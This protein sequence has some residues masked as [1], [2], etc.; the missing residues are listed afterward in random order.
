ME[1]KNDVI[2]AVMKV[3]RAMHR[4]PPKGDGL[5]PAMGRTLD[6]LAAN[7]GATSRELAE[8]LDVR[9]SSLTEM[10]DR[11]ETAGL[12]TREADEN[13]RRVVRVR[14]TEKCAAM[15]KQHADARAE[16][17]AKVSACFTEDEAAQFC[18]LCGRLS[19]HLEKLAAEEA[20][21][22]VGDG[23]DGKEGCCHGGPHHGH[24]HRHG[25]GPCMRHGGPMGFGGPRGPRGPMG[26]GG[27]F[28]P[29]PEGFE[30]DFPPPPFEGGKDGE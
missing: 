6:I 10:L 25:H 18:E 26:M 28:P 8:L 15:A 7:D 9:P 16:H 1:N 21:Q 2:F 4:R 3:S 20:A 14:M 29:P 17:L 24:G 30:G 5:P 23:A 13:D 19:D 12:V 22:R 11:M 27:D